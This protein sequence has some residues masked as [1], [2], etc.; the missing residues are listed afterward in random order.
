MHWTERLSDYLDGDL[1]PAERAACDAHLASC[2]E[3]RTA[4]EEIQLVASLAQTD[5]DV[6]P[7]HDLWPGILARIESPRVVD[8]AARGPRR[9]SFTLPQL[10]LAASLLIAVSAGVAYVATG[11]VASRP[12][13][14]QET[15]IQAM[16][17]PMM[18]PSAD[19]TPANFADAQ[20]DRAVTDLER[21]LVEQRDEL[22]PRTVMVIERNLAAIDEAIRQ[23]RAAL[24]SDPAN[25]FLN[26]HLA[27][28]RRR[29]IDLLRHATTLN[30]AGD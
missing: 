11:R 7:A 12:T 24:E 16:A 20:F 5:E 28:S 19:I 14:S 18:P 27:D 15:P 17:E 25:P 29:K 22:D 4:L 26:S 13:S 23:A 6:L 1:A 10:A 8:F 2:Q 21:V 3:C 30:S 9:I